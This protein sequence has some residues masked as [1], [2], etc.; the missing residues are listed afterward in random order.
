[1]IG[2]VHHKQKE[3]FGKGMQPGMIAVAVSCNTCV[4][5]DEKTQLTCKWRRETCDMTLIIG[6]DRCAVCGQGEQKTSVLC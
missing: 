6:E 5:K 1:M 2:R 3:M 4:A